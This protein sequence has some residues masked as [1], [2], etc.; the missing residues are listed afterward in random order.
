MC[1]VEIDSPFIEARYRDE[2]DRQQFSAELRKVLAS[3]GLNLTE[4]ARVEVDE[5]GQ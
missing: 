4:N 3:R 1:V 2:L 5:E